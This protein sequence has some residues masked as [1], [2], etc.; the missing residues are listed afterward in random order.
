MTRVQ[1]SPS[2]SYIVANAARVAEWAKNSIAAVDVGSQEHQKLLE[3]MKGRSG[4]ALT[5]SSSSSSELQFDWV[6]TVKEAARSRKQRYR[7]PLE[8]AQHISARQHTPVARRNALQRL[9]HIVTRAPGCAAARPLPPAPSPAPPSAPQ[10]N[11]AY[12]HTSRP[13]RIG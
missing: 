13:V 6:I 2:S 8:D 12:V 7:S 3:R 10:R 1:I 5:Q 11:H 4:V 9:W